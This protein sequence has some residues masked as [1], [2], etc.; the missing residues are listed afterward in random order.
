MDSK[1]IFKILLGV[2]IIFNCNCSKNEETPTNKKTNRIGPYLGQEP[3][4]LTPKVFAPG[5]IS[6]ALTS[7]YACT[8]SPDGKEFYFTRANEITQTIMVSKE[9]EDGWTN[10]EPVSFSSGY[11]AHEPHLTINNKTIYF[12]WFRA[13]PSGETGNNGDYG[14][15]ATDRTEA[16][17]SAARYVGQ[18]MFVSSSQD[19][20]LYI[21][22]MSEQN[23]AYLAKTSVSNGRFTPFERLTGGMDA[24]RTSYGGIAHPC[25]AP[26]GSFIIFDKFGEHLFVCFKQENNT[27]GTAIDLALH[28]FPVNSGIA[29]ISPD[30]LYLF[31]IYN[32]D[33]YW[34]STDIIKK[35]Y[36][37][38]DILNLQIIL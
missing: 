7:D 23:T 11:G 22:D 10:P 27:W 15:W 9:L 26:D 19:G 24:I 13:L 31:Y 3:P 8:F 32:G 20:Q 1:I 37:I 21:T 17:W 2:A 36:E 6:N 14:I 25:I 29:S 16:G 35:S 30:G 34:V 38:T 18:G 33:I 5:F 4:G 28:G 12:G